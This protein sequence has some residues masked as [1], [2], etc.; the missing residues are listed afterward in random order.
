MDGVSGRFQAFIPYLQ[1]FLMWPD[2]VAPKP[3]E[4]RRE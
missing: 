2:V 1:A 4:D 3:P